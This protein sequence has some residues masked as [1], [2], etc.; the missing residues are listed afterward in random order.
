MTWHYHVTRRRALALDLPK[1]QRDHMT[2]HVSR[3]VASRHVT[4]HHVSHLALALDLP[5]PQ[6]SVGPRSHDHL[7]PPE[8]GRRRKGVVL[9]HRVRASVPVCTRGSRPLCTSGSRGVHMRQSTERYT[10]GQRS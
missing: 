4:S 2:H 6:R 3:H 1:P 5:K 9:A 10:Q 7:P 8:R